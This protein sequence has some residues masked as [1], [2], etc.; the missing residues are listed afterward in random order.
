MD[1]EQR[2]F[3]AAHELGYLILH[4][5]SYDVIQETENKAQEQEAD[6]FAA[7]FLMPDV[8]FLKEWDET[9]GRHWVERVFKVTSSS[10]PRSAPF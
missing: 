1:V 5:S 10:P 2:V 8:G 6:H 9:S 7:H 4:L 3:T